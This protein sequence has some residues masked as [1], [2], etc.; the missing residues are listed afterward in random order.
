M[1]IVVD[2]T[3]RLRLGLVRLLVRCGFREES[4]LVILALIIGVLTA[5][6]AVAFHQLIDYIRKLLYDHPSERINL[7]GAG[8]ILLIALPA[9]G[10]LVVG[11]FNKFVVRSK[12][13][14]GIV[15][16]IETV[17]TSRGN[18]RKRSAIEQI[19]ASAVTI[20][21][22]GS[23]GAEGPIVQI[24]AGLSAAVGALFRISRQHLPVLVG[25]GSAA[26]ISAIFNA[27]LGGLLFTLEIVMQEFSIRR[28][29]PVVVASVVANV[30]TRGIYHGVL[31]ED[32]TAI[33]DVAAQTRNYT[34]E[35]GLSHMASFV[36]LGI[37]CG[38]VGVSLTLLMRWTE[39]RFHRMKLPVS[40][41]PALGGAV[42]G[43]LGI[44]YV[45]VFGQ[46]MLKM[47]KPFPGYPMPAFQGDGYGVVKILL[48]QEFYHSMIGWKILI[49]L[50][51]LCVLKLVATCLTLGSGGAGGVIAP[52][53]FMGAVIGGLAGQILGMMGLLGGVSPHVY[54]LVGMSGVLAACI[55]APLASF[56]ILFEVTK[57]YQIV[58]PGMLCAIVATSIAQLIFRDSI[59][60]MALRDRGLSAGASGDISLLRRMTVEQVP[61]QPMIALRV[62]DPLTAA[63]ERI[64]AGNE[65]DFVVVDHQGQYIGMMISED[66]QTALMQR[67]A[68]PLLTVG[69][70]ARGD[71][72]VLNINDDLA[73]ALRMF[74]KFE[75]SHLP[76]SLNPEQKGHIIG[77]ISRRAL[78]KVYQDA[79]LQTQ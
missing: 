68:I 47:N 77:L 3:T 76:V 71:I 23:A 72:P 28:L 26:G 25:C 2:L 78:M 53:L 55:H 56:L 58:L 17:I 50:G 54:A 46:L 1:A 75:L 49:L 9:L 13:G 60:T 30:A 48:T 14:H 36:G 39:S 7:Y 45:L 79:L 65:S 24:G 16:V 10:G 35:L 66:I 62:D 38:L 15:D 70:L 73:S 42:V 59:Y 74:A 29:P 27:P 61:L 43:A 4:F 32:Y 63:L 40:L 6:A 31:H 19:L 44:L 37:L 57:D 52:S 12:G 21:S 34:Y 5:G 67:E 41:R 11:L 8:I 69:E 18:I 33:F 51:G 20:G 64:D 22:G